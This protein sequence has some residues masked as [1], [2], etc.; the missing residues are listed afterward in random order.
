MSSALILM[1]INF[2]F[3]MTYTEL[4]FMSLKIRE[5]HISVNE[6]ELQDTHMPKRNIFQKICNFPNF[7]QQ[8]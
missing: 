6:H 4:I 5:S 1:V 2:V 7:P 8:H 3:I